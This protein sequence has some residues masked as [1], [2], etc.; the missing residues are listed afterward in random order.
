M[1]QER[2][3]V[4]VVDDDVS[5]A[6]IHHELVDTR[7]DFV[8]VGE[9][10]NGATALTQIERLDPD[11][12]LL[13]IYLPDMSGLEVLSR[14][15][16]E[17]SKP[18]EVIAV[19]A[20]RDLDSVREARANGVRHYLVKP[21]TAAALRERLDQVARH[22]AALRR[23]SLGQPLTQHSVDEI[24]ASPAPRMAPP[25]PKGLS[26]A[27]LERVSTTLRDSPD[28]LSAYEVATTVGMS[29]V[30]ARRY[31]EHLVGCGLA[32]VSPRYGTAGR[33]ENRY[34]STL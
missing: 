24:I 17:H 22:H 10:H 21:F 25:L 8:V 33:P 28:D 5:V 26:K 7:P 2:L 6:L 34:R 31:L 3:R 27:T 13:D 14:L 23:N 15:R 20:A 9:A 12:V 11:V 30:S 29:R 1:T 18:V 16:L 19:T 32:S 4:L